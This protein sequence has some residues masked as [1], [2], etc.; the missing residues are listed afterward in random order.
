[1]N[2][3]TDWQVALLGFALVCNAHAQDAATLAK[4][5]PLIKKICD[6]VGGCQNVKVECTVFDK[7]GNSN[8]RGETMWS[9]EAFGA[10]GDSF[11][12]QGG[13][14]DNAAQDWFRAKRELSSSH[15]L[16]REVFPHQHPCTTVEAC[17]P[18]KPKVAKHKKQ[19]STSAA[20]IG[21]GRV[22]L[23]GDDKIV[24]L[25]SGHPSIDSKSWVNVYTEPSSSA[26]PNNAQTPGISNSEVLPASVVQIKLSFQALFVDTG[27]LYYP[28]V[29]S[30]TSM[31]NSAFNEWSWDSTA[32]AIMT[33]PDMAQM[34]MLSDDDYK[35]MI[36]ETDPVLRLSFLQNKFNVKPYQ[37]MQIL[38]RF[39]YVHPIYDSSVHVSEPP[40]TFCDKDIEYLPC[41]LCGEK[42]L[43]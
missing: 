9:V 40:Q 19:D 24:Y 13:G 7:T 14:W 1:M 25:Y 30:K 21:T 20:D 15:S 18:P 12:S 2:R 28:L 34:I 43:Q 33:A 11:K 17:D 41:G 38:G 10:E 32:S 31:L 23:T 29:V 16:D 6:K 35:V 22:W 36:K 39:L 27:K 5:H 42:L 8:L 26:L 37:S 3:V 4:T